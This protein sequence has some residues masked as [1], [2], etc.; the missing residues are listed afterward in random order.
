MEH[1]VPLCSTTSSRLPFQSS[2]GSPSETTSLHHLDGPQDNQY[3]E[4]IRMIGGMLTHYATDKSFVAYGF[5]AI[6]PGKKRKCFPLSG[7]NQ[8][9]VKGVQGIIDVYK[10]RVRSVQFAGP[11][12]LAPVISEATRQVAQRLQLNQERQEYHILMIVTDGV[13]ND[14]DATIDAAVAS[15]DLPIS[16]VI[17]GVGP[18]EF[19][20]M[21]CKLC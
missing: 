12:Y 20:T 13:V 10:R 9:H 18:S 19:P 4:V 11:S 6:V 3:I 21:V 2:N 17:V 7:N 16:I 5:G 8:L 1:N 15:S 14:I